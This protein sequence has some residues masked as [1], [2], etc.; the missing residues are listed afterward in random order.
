[1]KTSDQDQSS[2]GFHLREGVITPGMGDV[3]LPADAKPGEFHW[4]K[5]SS[6]E[7]GK[8][9]RRNWVVNLAGE[10]DIRKIKVSGAENVNPK[11]GHFSAFIDNNVCHGFWQAD[12]HPEGKPTFGAAREFR[13]GDFL[14]TTAGHWGDDVC[15][16]QRRCREA[17]ANDPS[18]KT[19]SDRSKLWSKW[20]WP[21]D[22]PPD[23]RP[24]VTAKNEIMFDCTGAGSSVKLYTDDLIE[25]KRRGG[26]VDVGEPLCDVEIEIALRHFADTHADGEDTPLASLFSCSTSAVMTTQSMTSKDYDDVSTAVTNLYHTLDDG[27]TAQS[28]PQADF[29]GC[30]LRLAGHDFMD[31]KPGDG[32]GSD[33]CTNL[34]D[35]DNV[36]LRDCLQGGEHGVSLQ[37]AYK[38]FCSKISLADF[39]VISAEALMTVSRKHV[40]EKDTDAP[41]IDFKGHFRYGRTSA[42]NCAHT[43]TRLPSPEMGCQANKETFIDNMGLDWKLTTALMGVHTLGRARIKNSGYNGRWTDIQNSRLFNN[44][45]FVSLLGKAWAPKRAVN[46]NKN[47]NQWTEISGGS[48]ERNPIAGVCCGPYAYPSDEFKWDLSVSRRRQK[49]DAIKSTKRELEEEWPEGPFG[50]GW[51]DTLI[52]HWGRGGQTSVDAGKVS[53]TMCTCKP[54]MSYILDS[55][56]RATEFSIHAPKRCIPDD[57]QEDNREHDEEF[58][59]DTDMCLAYQGA[60]AEHQGM[61]CAWILQWHLPKG[62][63]GRKKR[64]DKDRTHCGQAAPFC[65]GGRCTDIQRARCCHGP[66]QPQEHKDKIAT[67]SIAGITEHI[68]KRQ[69]FFDCTDNINH[70]RA[71]GGPGFNAARE[72]AADEGYWLEYFLVAWQKATSNGFDNL[73]CLSGDESCTARIPDRLPFGFAPGDQSLRR[74]KLMGGS[75]SPS[76]GEDGLQAQFPFKQYTAP[77]CPERAGSLGYMPE[78]SNCVHTAG[79]GYQCPPGETIN[80]LRK[81]E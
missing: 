25:T 60:D 61:C 44:M 33:A 20:K 29:A 23:Q 18:A 37:D 7:D 42:A 36:G 71:R 10:Y 21:T 4:I 50:T 64:I 78:V 12:F 6:A 48:C 19:S 54:G 8:E 59:L 56:G 13:E 45:Y 73:A 22:S 79:S 40:L 65:G 41:V 70:E 62:F 43:A 32:G 58:M 5:L 77:G 55:G 57:V 11:L 24:Q 14:G 69:E 75:Y 34:D 35:E 51:N 67:A 72:F 46:G 74:H 47:K 17:R 15:D 66:L 26:V 27:C 9:C 80:V 76:I 38:H 39:L 49:N 28:C 16:H 81:L 68:H 52:K 3:S 31:F 2:K 63:Y 53:Q 1:V 30:V